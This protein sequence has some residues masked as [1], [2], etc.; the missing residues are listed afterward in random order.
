MFVRLFV[1][2]CCRQ[3][4]SVVSNVRIKIARKDKY[5]SHIVRE[6][7]NKVSSLFLMFITLLC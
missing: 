3:N 5:F 1:F 6:R 7:I 2:I 4:L